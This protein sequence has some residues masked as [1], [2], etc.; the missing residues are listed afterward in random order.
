MNVAVVGCGAM[1]SRM[2]Q[3]LLS[4][5]HSV[6][7]W[8]RDASRVAPLADGGATIG[9]TPANTS[10]GTEVVIIMVADDAALRDVSEGAHGLFAGARQGSVILQMST[11][12]PD[13]LRRLAEN[14]PSGVEILD[15]PVLGSVA[16]AE[17]GSLQ[18]FVGGSEA[19][20][21]RVRP[22]LAALG[23]PVLLGDFGSG[24]AAKLVANSTLLGCLALLGESISLALGLG[25]SSETAF[26]VLSRT[27]LSAQASRRRSALEAGEF[28]PRFSLR[29]AR[30]D[31]GIVVSTAVDVGLDL[32]IAPEVRNWL[33]EAEGSGRGAD[34]YSALLAH[35]VGEVGRTTR[36]KG[37][38]V[39][40]DG[41]TG[42]G[43]T[44]RLP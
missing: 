27:P 20:L 15:A 18:I 16:E 37:A 9:L 24:T 29:L 6:S 23:D 19:L 14:I 25:L 41:V 40:H 7:V 36:G 43:S 42:K 11:V 5:G 2:A 12:S 34:D 38:E 8:N 4:V 13:A 26:Q 21:V 22:V 10:S 31:E 30:K 17:A 33:V 28:P 3:R 44:T 1:G 39:D 35:I 32:K